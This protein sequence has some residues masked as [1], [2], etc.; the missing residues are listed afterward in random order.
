[1]A[2]QLPL[3]GPSGACHPGKVLPRQPG[4]CVLQWKLCKVLIPLS[5]GR[6]VAW[7]VAERNHRLLGWLCL[8]LLF[9]GP[10]RNRL[11]SLGALANDFP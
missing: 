8:P 7:Q 6:V 4:V 10:E 5:G 9:L 3:K 2:T 1:M 11:Q